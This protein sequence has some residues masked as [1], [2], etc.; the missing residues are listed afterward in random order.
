M[1]QSLVH[2]NDE[3]ICTLVYD[4]IMRSLYDVIMCSCC[5]MSSCAL[6]V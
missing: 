2:N 1:R 3:V 5:M 4:V 6:V